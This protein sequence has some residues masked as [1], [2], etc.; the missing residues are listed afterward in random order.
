MSSCPH[1]CSAVRGSHRHR[2][3]PSPRAAFA[4]R[5]WLAPVGQRDPAIRPR[6]TGTLT[7][8]D[9]RRFVVRGGAYRVVRNPMYVADVAVVVG[10]GIVFQSWFLFVWAALLFVAFHLFVI[11][12]EEPTLLSDIRRRLRDLLARRWPL[13]PAVAA[14]RRGD[15]VTPAH[16]SERP[17]ITTRRT[18]RACCRA[19]GGRGVRHRRRRAD[20]VGVRSGVGLI[21]TASL[22]RHGLA[23]AD[24]R[25][26]CLLPGPGG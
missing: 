23:Q 26:G 2:G 18:A 3:S 17:R 8:I 25:T 22:G 16:L 13:D 14:A 5:R 21:R 20:D 11:T 24:N 7:P 1:G 15:S 4:R 19:A 10:S 6:G 12:Y 9:P